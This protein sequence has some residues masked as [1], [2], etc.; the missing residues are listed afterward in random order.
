MTSMFA[1]LQASGK[2]FRIEEGVHIRIDRVPL[3]EGEKLT[4]DQVLLL[5][6]QEKT[7]LGTPYVLG[8][9]VLATVISHEQDTK[10][11]IFKKRRRQNS[12]RKNGHRQQRTVVRID[13]ITQGGDS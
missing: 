1:F 9:K 7:L 10:V 11:I 5:Q 12:R 6:D 4:F 3:T 8:V 2:Q 13:S